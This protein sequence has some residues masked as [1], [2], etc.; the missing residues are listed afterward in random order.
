MQWNY[1]I[2]V[3]QAAVTQAEQ[4]RYE[5][6]DYMCWCICTEMVHQH[7]L[8][9]HVTKLSFSAFNVALTYKSEWFEEEEETAEKRQAK[10][11]LP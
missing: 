11:K 10:Q 7:Y 6:T 3:K 5:L 9:R 8:F 2:H 4:V 1:I